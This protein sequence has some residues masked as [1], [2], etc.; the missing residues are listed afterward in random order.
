MAV[1]AI[2]EKVNTNRRAALGTKRFGH[3]KRQGT[4][5]N[6]TCEYGPVKT[7][8]NVD[9]SPLVCT[10]RH[11]AQLGRRRVADSKTPETTCEAQTRNH[12]VS[13]PSLKLAIAQ[14]WRL[15]FRR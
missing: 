12:S 2:D 3:A 8:L 6:G 15:V 5:T 10:W 13:K 9:S 14:G 1:T 7:L 4:L 11:T